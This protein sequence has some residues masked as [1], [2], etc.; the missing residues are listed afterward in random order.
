MSHHCHATS[1]SII[2]PPEMFMCKKHWFRL[3]KIMRGEIWRTYREGQCDDMNPSFEYCYIAKRCVLYL[4][5]LEGIK[6]DTRLYDLFLEG[7]DKQ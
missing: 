5:E 7:M 2:I 4:A 1:C 3:P 6:S